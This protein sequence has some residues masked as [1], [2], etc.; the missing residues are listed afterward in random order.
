M[1]AIFNSKDKN[2]RRITFDPCGDNLRE[3]LSDGSE[4]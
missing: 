2:T 4:E 1:G 3:K